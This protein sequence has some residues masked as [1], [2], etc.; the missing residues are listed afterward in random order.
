MRY[1]MIERS[2]YLNG[3]VE[4]FDD[5]A[6][7]KVPGVL[8]VFRIKG[9]E[10]GAPYLILADGV[11][12][13]AIS[14]WAAMKGRE[15]LQVTWNKGPN[16]AENTALFWKQNR[17]MLKG[18]GIIARE[19]GDFDA[20]LRSADS[21][22]TRH[23]RIPF[24]SHAPLEPQNCFAHIKKDSAHIIAPTQ[25]PSGASRSAAA[26]TGL[27]REHI[28]IEISRIG[29]GFGRR[30]TNDYVAEACMISKKTGWPIKLVWT[31]EDDMRHDF[32][33]PSGLHEMTAGLDSESRV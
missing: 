30:L 25:M 15:A 29:G 1:A 23:Y 4:S 32:Y 22:I 17:E 28:H 11:A 14:T 13:V 20:A 31:R 12:V 26:V 5:A 3:H 6:A 10:P 2:P 24:V 33:R 7:R 9:P 18:K 19:D 21:S 16:P 8:D 27:E